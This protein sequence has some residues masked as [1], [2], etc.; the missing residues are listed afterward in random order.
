MASLTRCNGRSRELISL[1]IGDNR[2][3]MATEFLNPPNAAGVRLCLPGPAIRASPPPDSGATCA[4][5]LAARRCLGA[6]VVELADTPDLGSGGASRGGSS[7]SARRPA[8]G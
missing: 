3:R 2:Y 4:S 6:G 8:T 7:P 1:R 5:C